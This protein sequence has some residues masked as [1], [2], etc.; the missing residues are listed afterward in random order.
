M[1]MTKTAASPL[2]IQGGAPLRTK[3]FPSYVTIGEEEKR[4]VMEVMDTGVLSDFLGTWSP[5]FYGGSRVRA[6][7][8]EWAECFGIKNAVTVNSATSA[9]IAAVGAAGVGPGDEVI[10]SP[11]TMTASASCVLAFNAVPVFA[12]IDPQTYCI[13]AETIQARLTPRTRAIVVVDIF[14]HPADMDPIM[15]LARKHNLLVIE[16]AAQA[17]GAT[18]QGRPAGTLAHLGIFSLNY[19]KTIHT[20][21]GGVVVTNDDDLA[22][23]VQMIRNHAEVVATKK[24]IKSL[25]SMLGYNF[26]MTEIE[27]AIGRE[28]LKKLRR[29]HPPRIEAANYLT[30]HLR[31]FPFLKTPKVQPDVVHGW[32][33]YPFQYDAAQAGVPRA[34]F[35]AAVTAEGVPLFE[36]YVEPIYL[37]PLYQ[38]QTLYGD[39]GCP[40]RCPH[41][42]GHPNYARG[43][44]P[45]TEQMHF[46][47]LLFTNLCHAS[48]TRDDLSDFVA[49][50]HKVNTCLPDLVQRS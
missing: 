4:A 2:A 48:I 44:C 34:T 9:L 25:V 12:D 23:R 1:T 20:G 10:V 29:L 45:V 18:Y 31:R 41:Y 21:E 24:P 46:E 40:F 39:V 26:R 42:Q 5:Q 7:E 50:I 33:L 19:H 37:Q 38:Q 6:L 8:K 36:G 22:D 3:P 15:D 49:A 30:D 35:A 11:Y 17:P 27:A 47:N 32:Y 14:G 13:S 16:D 28:Q 43:L